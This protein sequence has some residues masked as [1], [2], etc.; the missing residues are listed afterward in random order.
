MKNLTKKSKFFLSFDFERSNDND[1]EKASKCDNSS[2]FEH[3]LEKE[4]CL[5]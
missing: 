1:D 3:F 5:F 4:F 2:L